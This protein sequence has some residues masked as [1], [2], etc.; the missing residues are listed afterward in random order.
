LSLVVDVERKDL[1]HA[2]GLPSGTKLLD[3]S[4]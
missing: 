3:V 4:E 1:D 2:P